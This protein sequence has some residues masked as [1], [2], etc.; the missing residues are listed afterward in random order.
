M[1]SKIPTL[2][3]SFFNLWNKNKTEISESL[4]KKS[5]SL[6][7]FA[8]PKILKK[9][10][11]IELRGKLIISSYLAG[12][13]ISQTRTSIAHSI[14][15]PLTLNYNI[16]HGLAAS[17][18]LKTLIKQN[19]KYLSEN[20]IDKKNLEKL[21]NILS[22]FKLNRLI[23]SYASFEEIISLKNQMFTKNRSDNYIDKSYNFIQLYYN[24]PLL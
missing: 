23:L 19:I 17:F 18:T 12:I 2:T 5:L 8:L 11:D 13:A 15:Y 20:G 24:M 16:P 7:I 4:S 10:D 22:K 9:L 6:S 14:S 21:I 1:S 3:P